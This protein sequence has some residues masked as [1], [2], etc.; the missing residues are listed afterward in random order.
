ALPAESILDGHGHLPA[1]GVPRTLDAEERTPCFLDLTRARQPLIKDVEKECLDLSEVRVEVVY[2]SIPACSVV[3]LAELVRMRVWASSCRQHCQ[4]FT[5]SS[6]PAP[7]SAGRRGRRAV[8]TGAC[9]TN[10]VKLV[11]QCVFELLP[12]L[13]GIHVKKNRGIRFRFED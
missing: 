2:V 12:R 1:H 8:R 13:T 4:S 10:V 6:D 5:E 11:C 9:I 3:G 7:D